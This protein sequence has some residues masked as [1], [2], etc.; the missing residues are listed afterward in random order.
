[1]VGGDLLIGRPKLGVSLSRVGFWPA[2]TLLALALFAVALVLRFT[3]SLGAV[4]NL[5]DRFAWGLWVGFK[6]S[7][8]AIAGGAFTLMAVVH[9]LNLRRFEAVVRPAV[10]LALTSY[11]MF[12]FALLLDLGQ[13]W[14]I[15]HAMV[16]WNPRSVMFEVAWC[17]MLYTSVLLLEL[18]PMVFERLGLAPPRHLIRRIT[19]PLVIAG[20][21]LSTLHQSSLGSLYLIVPGK[22]HPLWYSPLIP[23]FFYLSALAG[24]LAM[25]ILQAHLSARAFGRTFDRDLLEPLARALVVLLTLY[26]L[27]RV[28][29][30]RRGG[31]LGAAI[32]LDYES[33]LFLLEMSVGVILPVLLLSRRAL[34]QRREGLVT[35]ALL[36]VLGVVLNRVNVAVTGL[37]RA[38]GFHYTPSAIEVVVFAGLVALG[39]SLFTLAVRY[40]PVFPDAAAGHAAPAG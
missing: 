14:R 4:T 9:V 26:G 7:A 28:I 15:W 37:E 25:L 24:G 23:V 35:G 2:V 40:L 18:S 39:F 17:V 12:I 10:V 1:L 33:L 27:I 31:A 5:D 16:F 20:F 3:T 13:P 29:A 34:R 38:A 8:I 21:I 22:L 32:A 36:A 30:L 11:L 6:L 19:T